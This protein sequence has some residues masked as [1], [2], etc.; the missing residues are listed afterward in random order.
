MAFLQPQFKWVFFKLC[1]II[2]SLG[3][4]RFRPGL[5]QDHMCVR[6]MNCRLIWDFCPLWFKHCRVATHCKKSKHS[7]LCMT[8]ITST[9][10]QFCTWMWVIW[11]FAP[12]VKYSYCIC[13]PLKRCVYCFLTTL[14]SKSYRV[15]IISTFSVY[16]IHTVIWKSPLSSC[17]TG[18]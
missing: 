6:N 7:M 2:T 11:A 17:D 9:I 8:D 4:Y 3:V 12:P 10:F 5:F 15:H 14:L 13:L 1:M 16:T 18:I